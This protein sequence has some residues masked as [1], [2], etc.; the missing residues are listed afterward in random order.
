MLAVQAET[1]ASGKATIINLTT[2]QLVSQ[3]IISEQSLCQQDA[4]WIVEDFDIGGQMVP[5]ADF[6]TV[7]FTSAAAQRS[8]LPEEGPENANIIE[9]W[10]DEELTAVSI[11]GS[12]VTVTYL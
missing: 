5:F 12:S 6:G 1:A 11:D 8:G 9:M 2:G 3:D 7:T 10:Q 4:E